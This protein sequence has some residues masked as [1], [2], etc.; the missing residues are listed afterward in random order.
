M[1]CLLVCNH[2]FLD[3]QRYSRS[4]EKIKWWNFKLVSFIRTA[5][6]IPNLIPYFLYLASLPKRWEAFSRDVNM[7]EDNSDYF[8]IPLNKVVSLI[9]WGFGTI[10]NLVCRKNY[11]WFV[12]YQV[13]YC[14]KLPENDRYNF[15]IGS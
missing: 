4:A 7:N 5:Y 15:K 11:D 14:S 2:I 10:V 9:F 12:T 8:L 1:W 6:L 3:G 13:N